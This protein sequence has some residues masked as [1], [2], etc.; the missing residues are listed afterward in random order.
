MR[1]S[2]LRPAIAILFATLLPVC[3]GAQVVHHQFW[4]TDGEIN[5]IAL[6]NNTIYIGGI[7][8]QVGP[9]YG[10]FLGLDP[11][12]AAPLQPYPS[13]VGFVTAVAPDGAGGWYVGGR[14][15][16]VQ[17]QPRSCLAQIDASGNVTSFGAGVTLTGTTSY[18]PE[19]D[20][21]A[22]SGSTVYVAGYFRSVN[23][24]GRSNL[25]A[26]DAASGALAAW[27]PNA[28]YASPDLAWIHAMT[29]YNGVVY[30]GG[31]FDVVGVRLRNNLAGLDPVSGIA[32]D[33]DPNV[34]G[35]VSAIAIRATPPLF[36]TVIAG[37]SFTSVNGTAFSNIVAIDAGTGLPSTWAPSINGEVK[38]ILPV[39][40]GPVYVGGS[41]SA[42]GGVTRHN[43]GALDS[44]TGAATAWDPNADQYVEG[45][46]ISGSTMY[47]CGPFSSMGGLARRGLAAIDV[48]S[49]ATIS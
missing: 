30:V 17:G 26:F 46:Q 8:D 20:A 1:G 7:F 16:S 13:V 40:R 4:G 11:T 5:T 19:V 10:S 2:L 15:S 6:A 39:F 36:T 33:W 32:T 22:V 18:S 23:G 49:G 28:T 24:Q 41:F 48:A 9:A 27:N 45:L 47:A 43:I 31:T 34:N 12:T 25:A 14:L 37:G 44:N 42:I 38:A 35:R 29:I 3:A 21:I